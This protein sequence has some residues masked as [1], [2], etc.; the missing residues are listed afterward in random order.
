MIRVS[1]AGSKVLIYG[2]PISKT[3]AN[4]P[5]KLRNKFNLSVLK[6][7]ENHLKQSV[8]AG[9]PLK[10]SLQSPPP[11]LSHL[12]QLTVRTM[13]LRAEKQHILPNKTNLM[14][15]HM[16]Q[17]QLW[18]LDERS[19][20]EEQELL[21]KVEE[22]IQGARDYLEDSKQLRKDRRKLKIYLSTLEELCLLLEREQ[23]R[24]RPRQFSWSSQQNQRLFSH[25]DLSKLIEKALE[26]KIDGTNE[27]SKAVRLLVLLLS[28]LSEEQEIIPKKAIKEL[29]GS[30]ES[31]ILTRSKVSL[32][33]TL[34]LIRILNLVWWNRKLRAEVGKCL[35]KHFKS[36]Y[37]FKIEKEK[38]RSTKLGKRSKMS[39]NKPNGLDEKNEEFKN[40]KKKMKK[41][42]KDLNIEC[43]SE[44]FHKVNY[45]LI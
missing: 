22:R 11:P 4:E 28:D 32:T 12:R 20:Q 40:E 15:W 35:K 21:E 27:Q 26:G 39:D 41:I 44:I 30:K 18:L 33:Q 19:H 43:E 2:R 42:W 29:L 10:L 13:S 25:K 3:E 36:K 45:I 7:A 8:G 9:N 31:G 1:N 16:N 17:M 5:L 23:D 37:V 14:K 38:E 34:R 24:V 6:T